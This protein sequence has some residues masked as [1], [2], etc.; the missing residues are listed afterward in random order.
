MVSVLS[1]LAV[2]IAVVC[3]PALVSVCHAQFRRYELPATRQVSYEEP[4]EE[5]IPAGTTDEAAGLEAFQWDN[6]DSAGEFVEGPEGQ[7][8][9][10][11]SVSDWV[12]ARAEALIPDGLWQNRGPTW[13]TSAGVTL[14]RQGKSASQS[15]ALPIATSYVAVI[16]NTTGGLVVNSTTQKV[17]LTTAGPT[18]RIVPGLRLT[19]GRNLFEDIVHRQ[20]S[21]EF[22]FLGLSQW[23]GTA[24]Q[25]GIGPI[26]T[27]SGSIAQVQGPGLYSYFPV[28]TGGF[29]TFVVP[30]NFSTT[31]VLYFGGA[32]NMSIAETSAM[33]NYE[34]NY[35]IGRLPRPDRI[36]HLPDG[37][38]VPVGTPT[39]VH[40][41]LAGL[42]V[43]TYNDTFN[44]QS[45]GSYVNNASYVAGPFSGVYNVKTTNTLVGPQIGG[46]VF[47]HYNAWTLGVRGKAGVYGNS[48]KQI[49]DVEIIDP[50]FGNSSGFARGATTRVAFLGD[51]G[52]VG[53]ARLTERSYFRFSYDFL[54]A[55]GL[56]NAP[57]QLQYTTNLSSTVAQT[58]IASFKGVRSALIFAGDPLLLAP[59][60]MVV[61]T[62]ARGRVIPSRAGGV[63]RRA[64]AD[65]A[66]GAQ[67][68]Q[69]R[70]PNW[71]SSYRLAA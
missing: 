18:F 29:G 51:L 20:H 35:R 62:V 50:N 43:F 70:C 3:G 13:Y 66:D 5:S 6:S 11:M 19:V 24:Y 68:A 23:A 27:I 58:D 59:C 16:T 65:R 60:V 55:G 1:K 32:S 42:R 44:W 69:L 41:F 9:P 71:A 54:W 63:T 53:T 57:D 64:H 14:L 45:S 46:D 12:D 38:W 40:S 22:S 15:E 52:F 39:L 8:G 33:N 28:N 56:A 67:P 49:S 34:V 61:N 10:F 25:N 26:Q 2:A 31:G 17:G 7:E 4:V 30:P 36:A 47:M 37:T 48:T 21:I